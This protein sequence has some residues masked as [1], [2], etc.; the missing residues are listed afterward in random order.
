MESKKPTKRKN[1]IILNF[2]KHP[3]FKSSDAQAILEKCNQKEYGRKLTFEDL[4]VYFIKICTE[5]EIKAIQD[6]FLTPW[7]RVNKLYQ[8]EVAEKGFE[9]SI[10]DFVAKKMKI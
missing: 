2:N 5:K 1:R 9:G 10:Q 6:E 8:T 7:D 4:F 3:D